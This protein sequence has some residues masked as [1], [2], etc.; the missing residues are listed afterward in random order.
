M[1]RALL[2]L[3][4]QFR[5]RLALKIYLIGLLQTAVVVGGFF[6]LSRLLRPPRT[7]IVEQEA[8]F[9]SEEI[10]HKLDDANALGRE[11]A[12]VRE[13]LHGSIAIYGES[14]ELLATNAPNGVAPWQGRRP[15]AGVF[16][17]ANGPGSQVVTAV[18]AADGHPLFAVYWLTKARHAP[19]EGAQIII[20]VLVAIGVSSWLSARALTRPLADLAATARA[21]GQGRL[22]A[23]SGI[24]RKDEFGE[25]AKAFDE[26]ADRIE[27]LVR[28]EKELLANVSHEL[29]T[30]LA[31]IHVALDLAAEGGAG[32]ARE[33]LSEI[34]EDL[35]EL[36][37]IV[38][39]VLM[40]TRLS[41]RDGVTT[42]HSLPPL[43]QVS[44]DTR[45]LLDKALA[46]FHSVHPDRGLDVKLASDM[47]TLHADPVLLRRVIDNLLEN[48]HKYTEDRARQI[49]VVGTSENDVVVIEIRDR[50]IGIGKDDLLRVFDPFFRADRSRTRATGGLGLGLALVRSIVEAHGG[51]VVLKSE[52][53]IG[54][55]ARIELPC[56]SP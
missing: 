56:A 25:V 8:R 40:A 44:V 31:R 29:R 33:S 37:R 42:G 51:H 43:R 20:F 39:D 7:P 18:P 1:R 17:N 22:E 45:A 6:F 54:T 10:V 3:V 26:M 49:A 30:P 14:G 12:R 24:A 46:R 5:S 11:L 19:A 32:M 9:V 23:R 41:L 2:A 16:P 34:A 13:V 47:R 53:G 48:A 52:L 55:C 4:R 38:G 15:S 36:E 27:K 28:A 35:A 21:F 50:G